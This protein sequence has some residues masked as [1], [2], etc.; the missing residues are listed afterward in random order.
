M[1]PAVVAEAIM[2]LAA[3]L[4]REMADCMAAVVERLLKAWAVLMVKALLV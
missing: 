3:V 1:A 4:M 2:A